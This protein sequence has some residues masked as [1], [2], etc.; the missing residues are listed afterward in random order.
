MYE[1]I[2][3]PNVS[4]SFFKNISDIGRPSARTEQLSAQFQIPF[5]MH[6]LDKPKLGVSNSGYPVIMGAWD[7]GAVTLR[8]D[9]PIYEV[10]IGHKGQVSIGTTVAES[11]R[12]YG[13]WRCSD[14]QAYERG[15]INR[16]LPG[17]K[18]IKEPLMFFRLANPPVLSKARVIF[19][20][21]YGL[22]TRQLQ[23]ES[24]TA[25]IDIDRDGIDDLLIWDD[26]GKGEAEYDSSH[27][28]KKVIVNNV[29]V[30][31]KR[32]R[33]IFAN[34]AGQWYLLDSDEEHAC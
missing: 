24:T 18:K 2:R 27:K 33:L 32:K 11:R 25:H 4:P 26:G 31:F 23:A 16:L 21:Q 10:A 12:R 9:S 22:P 20:D 14:N 30:S 17:Y 29:D 28:L 15:T 13:D 5:R 8:L 6:V 19:R 3:L 7:I 1:Q 34:V